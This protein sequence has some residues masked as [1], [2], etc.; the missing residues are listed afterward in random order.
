MRGTRQ[1]PGVHFVT[2]VERHAPISNKPQIMLPI[3]QMRQRFGTHGFHDINSGRNAVGRG[4]V[5][6]F[7]IARTNAQR[8]F[9]PGRE[10]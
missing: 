2:L 10:L 7:Q 8:D 4:L 5:T 1:E 9:C 3:A 6:D